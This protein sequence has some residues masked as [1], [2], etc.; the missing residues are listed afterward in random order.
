MIRK[1]KLERERLLAQRL[2]HG[3]EADAGEVAE[4]VIQQVG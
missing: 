2:K 3:Y 4:K 1:G